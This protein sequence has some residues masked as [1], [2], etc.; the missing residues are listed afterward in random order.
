MLAAM[1]RSPFP[2]IPIVGCRT[3]D[4]VA[5]SLAACTVRLDDADVAAI[6]AT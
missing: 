1:M 4:Q 6:A 5:G 3:P 2:T